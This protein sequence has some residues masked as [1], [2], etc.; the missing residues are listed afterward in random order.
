MMKHTAL[1][2]AD[3]FALAGAGWTLAML[4]WETQAVMT[5]RLLGMAGAWS[6]LPSENARMMSEKAPAFAAATQAATRAAM[7]GRR[8]EAVAEAWAEPLR[9]RTSANAR[10]LSL[11]G[12][13]LK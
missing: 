1:K 6:V 10:R 2:G 4:A 8:P 3:P 11:R 9:R 13:R 7:A 12:P 5:M